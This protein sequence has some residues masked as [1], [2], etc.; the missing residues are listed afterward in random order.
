[1]ATIKITCKINDSLINLEGKIKRQARVTA[2]SK[3]YATSDKSV[4]VVLKNPGL[5]VFHI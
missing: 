1:M 2:M 3:K 5:E 4:I